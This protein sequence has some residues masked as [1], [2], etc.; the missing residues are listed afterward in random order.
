MTS[1]TFEL[2]AHL[3]AE[4][5]ASRRV[6]GMIVPWD[7]PGRTSLGE[8]AIRRGAITLP[9][10]PRRLRLLYGHDREQPI[11][12]ALTLEDTDAGLLGTFIVARTPLGDRY[13]AELDPDAPIRDGLSL[14]L[15]DVDVSDTHVIRGQ[16]TAVAAVPLPAYSDARAS[17]AAEQSGENVMPDAILNPLPLIASAGDPETALTA[18]QS[19]HPAFGPAVPS[20][21][22]A[23]TSPRSAMALLAEHLTNARM[24][25][26]LEIGR[27]HV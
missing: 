2:P 26:Q 17:L 19:A 6:T 14:E 10:N 12:A 8:L 25:G 4:T 20:Q 11:G 16:L 22:R 5:D 24:R 3:T 21:P 7:S 13:L 23:R 15:D 18:D 27:A 9:D 1:L